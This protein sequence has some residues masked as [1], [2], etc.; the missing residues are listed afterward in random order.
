MRK[1]I[2]SMNITLDGFMSGPHC[3]L[4]WHFNSW[5]EEM[6]QVAAEQLSRA[7]TIILGRITYRA[8]ARYW[9]LQAQSL[10]CARQDIAFADMMNTYAKIVFTKTLQQSE[11]NNS[12]LVKTS[13]A[14]EIASL[15][16]QPGKEMIIYGSGK[17]VAALMQ[18][19]MIDEYQLWIHPVIL[20]KGKPFFGKLR[21]NIG[22]KLVST[23]TFSSGV[24]MMRYVA[25]INIEAS[26]AAGGYNMWK[27]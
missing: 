4:D 11:W 12:K 15:K 25:G 6:A 9:P 16:Q 26:A 23:T 18:L 20:G 5:N 2:V 8:M 21:D 27:D 14:R 7:D 13:I 1:L 22:I 10:A 24:V 17:I 19:N 3:E